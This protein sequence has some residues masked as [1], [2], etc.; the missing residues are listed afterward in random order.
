MISLEH[1][2]VKIR[3]TCSKSFDVHYVT[4][5]Q[6]YNSYIKLI[7]KS[8][9]GTFIMTMDQLNIFLIF[10]TLFILLLWGKFRY[11]IIAFCALMAAVILGLVSTEEA[12]IGF[13]HP[14]TILVAL[15]LLVST[16]MVKSGVIYL[17][18]H[19]L[20]NRQRGLS[21]H[22]TI[23]SSTGALLSSF[24]NNIAA[25]AL[26]MPVDLQV[27]KKAK[28]TARRTLMPL[29]FA[30]ILGGMVTLI[31]TPPNIIIAS[32][33]EKNLGE[34]FTFFDFTPVGL[35]VCLTG[36]I[37]ISSFGW[38]L[39]SKKDESVK[40]KGYSDDEEFYFSELIISE[41]SKYLGKSIN[42]M[43]DAIEKFDATFIKTTS[44]RNIICENDK[45]T[46]H[47]SPSTLDEIRITL[48]LTSENSNAIKDFSNSDELELFEVLVTDSSRLLNKTVESIGLFWRQQTTLLGI[49][50][51]GKRL[52]K[53][54]KKTVIKQGDI[55]LLLANK[56][57]HDEV[58][59]WLGA[60]ALKD[61]EINFTQ[62]GKAWIALCSF[63]VAVI[64]SSTGFMSLTLA[65][66]L[67]TCFYI[68]VN[69]LPVSQIYDSIAWPIIVLLASMIP[70]GY[71][72]ERTGGTELIVNILANS[73]SNLPPW[74]LLTILMLITMTM[75][76]IL[77]NTAT[78]IV[79]A[80]IALSLAH[81]L[82]VNPDPF[83]MGVAVAA[84]CAFLTPIGHKNNTIIMVPGDYN[85]FDYWRMGL[86][87][88]VLVLIVS[89]P[90]ILVFWHF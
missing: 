30:T 38:R 44:K 20:F 25:L 27:A 60:L 3:F 54:I 75:S 58:I 6:P 43:S 57:T 14:A 68:F 24:I 2:K 21:S 52:K 41:G 19:K 78:T 53:E 88:Q 77:N 33:R 11:D 62:H 36:L 13:S 32:I 35:T 79:A 87:L 73:T 64:F 42:E 86:P 83:L 56:N 46:I 51:K 63:A 70:L 23:M 4:L 5:P 89:V 29:S 74:C 15:V 9:L 47:T 22:I 12:F 72:L 18:T 82:G 45:I 69:I 17:I 48:G 8:I 37:F 40:T 59:D 55:L 76:D 31:G 71:A 34:P 67:L 1:L 66:S 16:G 49:S 65:L 61:K 80:P 28:R 81:R 50:R 90:T 85:F 39:L 84:S 7:L 26:L 10:A